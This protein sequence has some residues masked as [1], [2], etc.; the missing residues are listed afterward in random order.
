VR[1]DVPAGALDRAVVIEVRVRPGLE[2][3]A[4][5]LIEAHPELLAA[6]DEHVRRVNERPGGPRLHPIWAPAVLAG[7]EKRLLAP[8]LALSPDGTRFAAPVRVALPLPADL[9]EDAVA[10][11]L[12]VIQESR[13]PDGVRWEVVDGVRV[14]RAAGTLEVDVTH[15]SGLWAWVVNTVKYPFRRGWMWWNDTVDRDLATLPADLMQRFT[16]AVL[17]HGE[18]R[19]RPASMPSPWETLT[20]LGF[21]GGRLTAPGERDVTAWLRDRVTRRRAGEDVRPLAVDEL[22]A[23]ALES[24]GGD[25]F[26]ALVLSHNVLRDN[27]DSP[28]LQ[29]AMAPLRGDGGD[30]R[31]A[32][33]H[34]FGTAIYAYVHAWHTANGS[35]H[36][37][38]RRIVRPGL[39]VEA[40]EG[41]VSGDILSDSKEFAVDLVGLNL[42]RRL[43]DELGARSRGEVVQATA[44]DPR[45]CPSEP[46]AG[47]GGADGG[48][49][50]FGVYVAGEHV[51]VGERAEIER[52]PCCRL[53]LWG[54]DCSRTVK[55]AVGTL[56]VLAGPFGTPDEAVR[57]YCGMLDRS[58]IRHLPL[59]AGTQAQVSGTRYHIDNAPRCR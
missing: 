44:F 47:A 57:T 36:D 24:T 2:A 34:L 1:I 30:E 46:G 18:W 59:A 51:L 55:D 29:D 5:T 42:G 56:T 52:T 37:V 33:Y 21:E 9:P 27:R 45:D 4:P 38:I 6:I 20:Y 31:G 26:Q 10:E 14:D 32:R 49:R 28:T 8:P 17:C 35:W 40:E 22:F 54:Q 53:A 58:S 13:G 19:G 39:M 50:E 3:D 7:A 11:A 23:K 15:F 16:R 41:V 43:Y 48:T 12:L 25:V